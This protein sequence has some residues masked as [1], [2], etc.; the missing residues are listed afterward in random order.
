MNSLH[1]F[2]ASSTP[3]LLTGLLLFLGS[4]V[5]RALDSGAGVKA[6]RTRSVLGRAV[7]SVRAGTMIAPDGQVAVTSIDRKWDQPTGTGTL[8]ESAVTP[9][10]KIS[11]REANLT[12]QPD[13]TI[14]T[15]GTFTDFD[16]QCYNFTNRNL[17]V[18]MADPVD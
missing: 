4:G 10:G 17:L 11:T 2:T 15:K 8:N 1:R 18:R 6:S 9:D 14:V 7:E 5:A 13:G 12:R 3:L 16:E